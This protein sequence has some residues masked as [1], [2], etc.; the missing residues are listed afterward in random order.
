MF[1]PWHKY[2]SDKSPVS[3]SNKPIP[4]RPRKSKLR[5]AAAAVYESLLRHA[6]VDDDES[7]SN[8]ETFE[9]GE[10]DSS[11]EDTLNG[12]EESSNDGKCIILSYT[13]YISKTV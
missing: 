4:D 10:V 6:T 5:K 8:D 12:V 3:S 13:N 1:Y 2:F 9:G 7:D 11:E